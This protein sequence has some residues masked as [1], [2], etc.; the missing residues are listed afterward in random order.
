MERVTGQN[1]SYPHL[2]GILFVFRKINFKGTSEE[3][4]KDLY[5]FQVQ[6]IKSRLSGK[7][8]GHQATFVCDEKGVVDSMCTCNS[9]QRA[10][11]CAHR[12]VVLVVIHREKN[13]ISAPPPNISSQFHKDNVYIPVMSDSEDENETDNDINMK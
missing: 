6:S 8:S 11:I 7:A 5:S 10:I 4:H 12:A 1:T 3:I 2:Q 13:N 9:G